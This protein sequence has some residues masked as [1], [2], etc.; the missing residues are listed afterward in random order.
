MKI[1]NFGSLNID[2]VYTVERIVSPGETI[3]SLSYNVY[4]GGKGLN[5]SIALARAGTPVFH[6]G[7]VGEDGLSL[8]ELCKKEGIDTKN[9]RVLPQSTGHT[10]IQVSYTG[11]NSIIVYGGANIM[12][13]KEM[14]DAALGGFGDGDFL[15]L[16]N[17]VNL[18]DYIIDTAHGRGMKIALNPSPFDINITKCNLQKVSIFMLNEIEAQQLTQ[19]EDVDSAIKSMRRLYPYAQ[20]VITLGARGAIYFDSG[21]MFT[22]EGKN[23]AAVDTTAAGDTFTGY[24]LASIIDGEKPQAALET[25]NAAAAISVTKKGAA[26]SIPYR[27][28]V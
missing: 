6:A 17:E 20:T 3:S 24:F 14:V 27:G 18:P 26:P 25:A 23:I 12:L 16:Q 4:E 5:Q 13:T 15:L 22:V 9:I 7:C 10:V 21:D 8:L 1:L 2:N 28:D 11:Q 19:T